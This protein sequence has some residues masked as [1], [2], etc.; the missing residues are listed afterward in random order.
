LQERP[1]AL[2]ALGRR[3]ARFGG[4]AVLRAA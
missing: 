2:T 4:E 1:F 3:L